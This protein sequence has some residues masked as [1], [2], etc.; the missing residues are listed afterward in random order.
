MGTSSARR[1]GSSIAVPNRQATV[2]SVVRWS[3]AGF[4]VTCAILVLVLPWPLPYEQ[5]IE[6]IMQDRAQ[7]LLEQCETIR[8]LGNL[9]TP[10]PRTARPNYLY[11]NYFYQPQHQLL[12]CSISKVASSSWMYQFNRWAGVPRAKIDSVAH[13]MKGLTRMYYPVPTRADVERMKQNVEPP[14]V[15]RFLLV[16]DPFDRFVSAYEDL[17]VRPQSDNYRNL[18]RFI[19]RE[20]YGADTPPGSNNEKNDTSGDDQPVPSFSDFTEFVLRRPN[21]LD[22]HWNT[23]YNLCDPCFLEPTV[24]VKL[25]TYDRDV[26]H[27][28]RLANVSSDAD[29]YDNAAAQFEG[30]RLN[31]NHH[32]GGPGDNGRAQRNST[33]TVDRLAEL[34][35]DQFERLYRRYELD[36]RLF[37]YDASHYFALYRTD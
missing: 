9:T 36:F 37:Q 17:I 16:R 30:Y 31:V 26:A 11:F 4:L 2:G 24:I 23:Y 6:Q 29:N 18:R 35:E 27:I 28:L 22:P 10:N 32:R 1:R 34:T 3:V 14:V 15:T 12:W 21:V 13:D 33:S 8:A 20:V 5:P 19:F 7:H 25:E